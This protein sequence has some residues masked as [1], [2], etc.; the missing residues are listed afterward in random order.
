MSKLLLIIFLFPFIAFAQIGGKNVYDFLNL[1]PNARIAALGGQNITTFDRDHNFA[2]YNPA[3]LSDSM[4]NRISLSVVNYLADVSYGNISYARR[5][6]KI[7]YMHAGIQYVNYG[8]FIEADEYGNQIGKFNSSE[9]AIYGGLARDFDKFHFGMNAKFIYS[10]IARYNSF[11]MVLDF[12]GVYFDPKSNVSVATVI[13]NVGL[14]FNSYVKKGDT[15]PVPLE[16]QAGI[17]HKLKYLPLRLSM[18]LTNLDQPK[19]IYK[20]P[21]KKQTFDLA[22][23]PIK[24]KSTTADN[25]F[26][27][28]IF[29]LE[30][31]LGKNINIR[32]GYNHQRRSELKTVSTGM[33]IRGFSMGLGL[34]VYKFNLDYAYANYH[35]IGGTHNFSVATGLDSFSK[36]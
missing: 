9:M 19:L 17:S 34:R 33:N 18:T 35:V 4:H 1:T 31:I 16:I 28:T 23:N 12:G 27:H 5:L 14:Q 15:Y 7:G 13:K 2:W 21:N 26:R 6:N 24:E 36:K 11:G 10:N 25:I 29:G 30:F 8:K 32:F 3:L 22:G 20:D